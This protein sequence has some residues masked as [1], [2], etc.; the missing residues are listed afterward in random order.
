MLKRGV[1]L[2]LLLGLAGP[3]A[4]K[5]LR[6]LVGFHCDT[7]ERVQ[8]ARASGRTETRWY[9]TFSIS[10]R[11]GMD[12]DLAPGLFV[13]AQGKHGEPVRLWGGLDPEV[14]GSVEARQ[15]RRLLDTVQVQGRLRVDERKDA[16]AVFGTLPAHTDRVTL[17]VAGLS[18]ALEAR[19][20][21]ID[22]A[23]ILRSG[24][25]VWEVS[26]GAAGGYDLKPIARRIPLGEYQRRSKSG[27]A[28]RL[29]KTVREGEEGEGEKGEVCY[30]LD[31]PRLNDPEPRAYLERTVLRRWYGRRGDE[32]QPQ[33]DT[34]RF[35]GE[36]WFLAIEPLND[37][38]P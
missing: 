29:W 18:S 17:Y 31:D 34:Y 15:G 4:A 5:A 24:R 25:E 12:R 1:L 32:I 16:I 27:E 13:E 33:L 19:R 38:K 36:D 22:Y 21:G 7:L 6:W 10:N 35:E 28:A 20:T 11:T 3:A 37:A 9:C 23:Q 8:L 14:Q 2:L 26:R 30:L